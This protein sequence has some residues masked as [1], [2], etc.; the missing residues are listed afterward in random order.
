[1]IVRRKSLMVSNYPRKAVLL[2]CCFFF[3]TSCKNENQNYRNYEQL[4]K[5]KLK[6]K[7]MNANKVYYKNEDEEINAYISRLGY[8]MKKTATGVRYMIY[9]NGNGKPA[10]KEKTV[11]VKYKVQLTDGTLCY[12]SDSTGILEFVLGHTDLPTGFQEGILQMKEGDKSLIISPSNLGY[13]L[14][15]DGDKIGA[16]AVLVYDAELVRVK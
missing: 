11:E 5:K 2:I 1:M 9:K 15:G 7:L 4:D 13:G 14:T 3:F 8:E 10:A 16:N 12:S 6:E